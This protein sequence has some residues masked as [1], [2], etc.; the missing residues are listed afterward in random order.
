MRKNNLFVKQASYMRRTEILKHHIY[1][2]ST[3]SVIWMKYFF[4]W[5]L[6]TI[7]ALFHT[8]A[9]NSVL[10]QQNTLLTLC[11]ITRG[12]VN[13]FKLFLH[14]CLIGICLKKCAK[15]A[16]LLMKNKYKHPP[17]NKDPILWRIYQQ[18]FPFLWHVANL[19]C[20]DV[21]LDAKGTRGG[22]LRGFFYCLN[23][24]SILSSCGKKWEKFT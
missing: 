8:I 4:Q 23:N 17:G 6:T 21:S 7:Q 5:C 10:G 1:F 13:F 11:T 19:W 18:S 15:F 2:I 14:F 16:P 3:L 20:I 24:L 12:T 22:K 9:L